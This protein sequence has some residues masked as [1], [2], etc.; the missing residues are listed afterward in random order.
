MIKTATA[1]KTEHRPRGVSKAS[2]RAAVAEGLSRV[3]A[4][5]YTL[6]LQTHNFHWN[7]TGPHFFALHQMFEQQYTEMAA[8]VDEIAERI[9]AV[10]HPA[11]GTYA[12]FTRLSSIRQIA[13]APSAEDMVH[14][15]AE[16]NETI[17]RTLREVIRVAEEISD[18]A[19][20]DLLV[21]RTQAHEKNTWML[22]STLQA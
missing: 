4:D 20:V 9:R 21:R 11:P 22:R 3:L 19:T 13:G 14:V 18:D 15:L 12:E 17:V 16:G 1:T 2:D 10:G 7:V 6:Y 5:T 8:A